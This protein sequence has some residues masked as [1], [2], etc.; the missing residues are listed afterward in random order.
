VDLGIDLDDKVTEMDGLVIFFLTGS[1]EGFE[2]VMDGIS[3]MKVCVYLQ[4]PR[5]MLGPLTCL[6]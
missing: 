1:K 4:T 2:G 3:T 5:Q 6:C